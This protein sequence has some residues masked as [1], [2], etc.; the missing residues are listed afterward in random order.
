MPF[1]QDKT[2][3]PLFLPLSFQGPYGLSLGRQQPGQGQSSLISK[4]SLASAR[5]QH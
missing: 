3:E 4:A 1:A 2:E 5:Q